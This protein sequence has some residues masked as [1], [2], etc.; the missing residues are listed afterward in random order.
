MSKAKADTAQPPSISRRTFLHTIGTLAGSSAMFKAAAAIGLGTGL[1]GCGAS[2]ASE[3][4]S[5][6]PS[7]PTPPSIPAQ[8]DD[9][10]LPSDWPEG[11]G[12]TKTVVILGAGIA[13]MTCA[14]EMQKLG[15]QCTI[16]EATNRAGGRCRTLRQGDILEETDSVQQCN[17]NNDSSLYFNIGPA[18]IPHHHQ[19]LLGYCRQFSISLE[20]FINEST[21]AFYHSTGAFNGQAQT[22]RQVKADSRGYISQLLSQSISQNALDQILTEAEKTTMLALLRQYGDLQNDNTY[23]GSSRA[24]FPGIENNNGENRSTQLN[25]IQLS[26]L[27]SSNFWQQQLN[28]NEDINQQTSMLQPVG[29]MDWIAQAFEQRVGSLI[30]YN[31]VVTSIAKNTNGVTIGYQDDT[32][33]NHTSAFD[34]CI[35]TIPTPV[36]NNISNDFSAEHKAAIS[37]FQYTRACKIAFQSE[38]FWQQQ[39]AI[40]GGISWTNQSITQL[41]YPSNDLGETLGII[42]GAYTFSDTAGNSFAALSPSQRLT[43]AINE[44]DLIHPQYRSNVTHGITVSWPKVPYQLGGWGRSSP[45]VLRQSD[46]NVFFAGEHLSVLQGWQEGAILSAYHAINSIVDRDLSH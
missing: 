33:N 35:C 16:L 4:P 2:N 7:E 36:L 22:I 42:I 19:L 17:F 9:Y 25:P 34:Y 12:N 39:N 3:M 29:G 27:L 10:P 32:G 21:A 1:S 6:T 43:Q 5:N 15:Y 38:R 24:G 30:T 44:G 8:P 41:W 45:G 40:Y 46:A 28:F 26:N 37:S 18:R 14:F 31:A 13:G 20:P 11:I 23:S